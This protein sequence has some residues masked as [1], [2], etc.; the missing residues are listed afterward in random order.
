MG[1]A[2]AGTL[3]AK[4]AYMR[5]LKR[6]RRPEPMPAAAPRT[7]HA[8]SRRGTQTAVVSNESLPASQ[9]RQSQGAVGSN[10][11]PQDLEDVIARVVSEYKLESNPEQLRAFQIVARHVCFHG[12]QLSMY[13]GGVGGTGKSYVIQAIL[14]LF[15]LLGR[16]NEIL[17]SAPT[18]A[19][20]VL[21]GGYTIH[22][23][24]LLPNEDNPDLQTLAVI[25]ENVVYLI[26]DEISMVGATLLSAICSRLQHAKGQSQVAEDRPFGGVSVIFLGDFG[27][28]RPVSSPSLYSHRYIKEPTVQDAQHKSTLAAFKGVYI[29]RSV[30]TVVMLRKNQRQSKDAPYSEMLSRVREGRSGLARYQGTAYD[31]RVLQKRLIQNFDG[32]TCS[33]FVDAPVIVGRKSIRD[34]LNRRLL[35]L[36]ADSIGA[37]VDVYY[38]IDK[39][40]G[41]ILRGP[42]RD[43]VWDLGSSTTRDSLGRLPLFPGMKVMIQENIVFAYHVVNGAVGTVKDIKYDE[44]LGYRTVS[45][46]YVEIPGAGHLLGQDEDVIPIFANPTY[47]TWTRRRATKTTPADSDSVSRLQPPLLPA[48][49]YT[50]Y[51]AQGRSLD[52]AI[53]DLDSCFSIQGAYVMLSR[54]RTSDGLA[55]LRP[56]KARKVEAE[57]SEELRDEFAR[58]ERLDEATTAWWVQERAARDA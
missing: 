45:V 21:I 16:R 55:I 1:E 9:Y 19:A 29:W 32:P 39:V 35:Q 28:L 4:H 23:L 25:W 33:R 6:K 3:R 18:G 41:K 49:A 36:H 17:V 38:A 12:P 30:S 46:V 48:Y 44:H 31:F 20:A 2:D 51:K 57:I 24:L 40:D 37:H 56:F 43:T 26:I 10:P 54:V 27:Q 58:L 7:S 42:A 47:F 11:T 13:I 50:D 14:H 5:L 15:T 22:S 8:P 34:A 53:V 52:A